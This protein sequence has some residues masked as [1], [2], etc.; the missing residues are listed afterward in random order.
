MVG[1]ERRMLGINVRIGVEQDGE[2][3]VM[4][5]REVYGPSLLF[6]GFDMFAACLRTCYSAFHSEAEI[7]QSAV[8]L[9]V[10]EFRA[11]RTCKFISSVVLQ[12]KPSQWSSIAGSSR[13]LGCIGVSWI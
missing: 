7:S 11:E 3:T 13:S 5:R 2:E 10:S 4:E 1:L 6:R 9:E 8:H 12:H